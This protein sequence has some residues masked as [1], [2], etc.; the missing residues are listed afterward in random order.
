[1]TA[2]QLK[3]YKRKQLEITKLSQEIIFSASINQLSLSSESSSGIVSNRGKLEA[4]LIEITRAGAAS[5]RN[6][7]TTF[8]I[9]LMEGVFC[10]H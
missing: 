2:T 10:G 5:T 4:L 3:L 6:F 9:E 1:M 7:L 8:A